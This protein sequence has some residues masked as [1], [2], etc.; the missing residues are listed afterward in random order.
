MIN[1]KAIFQLSFSNLEATANPIISKTMHKKLLK[2]KLRGE[3]NTNIL[4]SVK[5]IIE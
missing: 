4:P 2:L 1:K 5:P 3:Y